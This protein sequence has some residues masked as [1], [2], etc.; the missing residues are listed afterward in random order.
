MPKENN[1][2]PTNKPSPQTNSKI[3]IVPKLKKEEILIKG[4]RDVKK[5]LALTNSNVLQSEFKCHKVDYGI[6][7]DILSKADSFFSLGRL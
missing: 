6:N 4:R 5:H 7:K 1:F 2:F 3:R